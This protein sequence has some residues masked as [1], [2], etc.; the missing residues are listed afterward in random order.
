MNGRTQVV[1]VSSDPPG[2]EVIVDDEVVGVT[3]TFVDLPRRERNPALR[4]RKEGFA[5]IDLPVRRSPS[6]WLWGD[7][8]YTVVTGLMAGQAIGGRQWAHVFP[9]AA[10]FVFG[11]DLLTG[12]AFKLPRHVQATLERTPFNPGPRAE[13]GVRA[14]SREGILPPVPFGVRAGDAGTRSGAPGGRKP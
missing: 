1:A 8:G 9:Q 4:F 12:A 5:T 13:A 14:P 10:A 7:A 2:A 11:I 6:G 3:P